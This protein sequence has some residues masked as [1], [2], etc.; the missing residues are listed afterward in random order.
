MEIKI[1]LNG[2]ERLLEKPLDVSSLL[3][4][5]E[6]P[7]ENLIVELNRELL[8]KTKYEQTIIANGDELELIRFVGGG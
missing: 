4:M 1:K 7:A 3:L 2:E 6:L 8:H 5:L